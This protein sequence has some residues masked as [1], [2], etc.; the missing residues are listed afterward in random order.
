MK[1]LILL[2]LTAPPR[3]YEE[4]AVDAAY[5]IVTHKE[6]SPAACCG[7]KPQCVGGKIIHGDGHVTDCPC[8]DTCD[9]KKYKA[10]LH[11]PTVI[12]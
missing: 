10:I 11:P 1:A 6:E 9:C 5:A 8:P 4:V 2:L 12:R 7:G 3:Y